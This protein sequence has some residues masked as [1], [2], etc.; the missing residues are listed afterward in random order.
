MLETIEDHI[1]DYIP[2]FHKN[3]THSLSNTSIWPTR[4][5]ILGHAE[6]GDWRVDGPILK[7]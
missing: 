3:L 7:K 4:S 1:P 5:H 6:K 2:Y